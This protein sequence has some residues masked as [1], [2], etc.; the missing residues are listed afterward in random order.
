MRFKVVNWETYKRIQ[1]EFLK[2]KH[3]SIKRQRCTVKRKTRRN[4]LCKLQ[5]VAI[6]AHGTSSIKVSTCGSGTDVEIRQ[7]SYIVVLL[8]GYKQKIWASLECGTSQHTTAFPKDRGNKLRWILEVNQLAH[9]GENRCLLAVRVRTKGV[10]WVDIRT[11]V[12][13]K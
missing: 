2:V 13:D 8:K 1:A 12:G 6:A 3:S 10:F 9:L 5:E 11:R 7:E 4:S